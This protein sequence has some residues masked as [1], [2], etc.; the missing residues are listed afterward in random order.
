MTVKLGPID[1]NKLCLATHRY[2]AGTT[3]SRS[4]HHDGIEAYVCRYVVFLCQETAELHHDAWADGKD[5][6]HILALDNLLYAY[7]HHAFLS[8]ASVVSHDDDFV[9]RLANFFL[10]DDEILGA[11]CQ[12]GDDAVTGF[13]QGLYNGQHGSD[14]H[15]AT[16]AHDRTEVLDVRCA[17]QRAHYVRNVVTFV[18][19]AEL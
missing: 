4:I 6:I 14:T 18:Q 16:G 15:A 3:H 7:R 9:A 1:A 5:L 8:V 10:Q 2:A 12:N 13:F 17:A 11:T 19:G